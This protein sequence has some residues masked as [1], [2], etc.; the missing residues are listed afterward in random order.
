[1]RRR[2]TALIVAGMSGTTRAGTC[3]RRWRLIGAAAVLPLGVLGL[4]LA[5]APSALAD[6]GHCVVINSAT[7]TTSK[8]LQAAVTAASPGATLWV[9]GTC[10]GNTQISKSLTITGQQPG[11]YPAPTLNGGGSGSVLSIVFRVTVTLNNLV[12]TGGNSSQGGGIDDAPTVTLTVNDSTVTGNTASDP[13]GG[14]GG[15]IWNENG[16][17]TLN[18]STV[19][20]NTVT[21]DG[22]VGG[23]IFSERG[24]VTLNDSTVTGNTVTGDGSV[25]GGIAQV[26]DSLTLNGSTVTGNT[27]SGDG[28]GIWNQGT[29]TLNNSTVTG[30][31]PD[32]CA[33]P[34]SVPGCTN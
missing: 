5:S 16:S 18:D 13:E 7:N 29:A 12:I 33:P 10:T 3:S 24:S 27:A 1:M 22:S 17:V 31:T 20:E 11:G 34:G 26:V 28:G 23:G 4:T 15:G 6:T 32:N 9:R 25:G 2:I 21:G 30:N 19:S 8:T 14:A